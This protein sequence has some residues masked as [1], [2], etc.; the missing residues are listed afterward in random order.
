MLLRD[1]I[2]A[3]YLMTPS[4]WQDAAFNAIL[5][6]AERVTES[7]SVAAAGKSGQPLASRYDLLA[8]VVHDGKAGEGSYRCHIHRKVDGWNASVESIA[9]TSTQTVSVVRSRRMLVRLT[10]RDLKQPEM[11]CCRS[12]RT[13]T[14]YRTCG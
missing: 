5:S 11:C 6:L 12:R 1:S 9:L 3:I 10:G 4:K 13:G 2:A 14:R 7:E 8:N